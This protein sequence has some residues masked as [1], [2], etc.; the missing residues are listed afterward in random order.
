MACVAGMTCSGLWFKSVFCIVLLIAPARR[1]ST[2][3][4]IGWTGLLVRQAVTPNTFPSIFQVYNCVY[5]SSPLRSNNVTGDDGQNDNKSTVFGKPF[6]IL[7][8]RMIKIS[9]W[10]WWA[11]LK[12]THR[13]ATEGVTVDLALLIDHHWPTVMG[14]SSP[15]LAIVLLMPSK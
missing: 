6:Q 11:V 8:V 2:N 12:Q 14:S 7:I 4:A 15:A 13:V 9:Y 5:F 10:H 1:A 3:L